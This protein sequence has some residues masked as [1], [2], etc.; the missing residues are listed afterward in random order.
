MKLAVSMALAALALTGCATDDASTNA[1]DTMPVEVA[2]PPGAGGLFMDA[3]GALM[4]GGNIDFNISGAQPGEMVHVLLGTSYSEGASCPPPLNG[5][6]LDITLTSPPKILFSIPADANGDVSIS[7]G[8]PGIP[9]GTYGYLQAAT[10]G[11]TAATSNVVLKF[12][13]LDAG[14][15]TY[16]QQ[17]GFAG[18]VPGVSLDGFYLEQYVTDN[19]TFAPTNPGFIPS[20]GGDICAYAGDTTGTPSA[21]AAPCVGCSF[22]FDVTTTNWE[23]I[24]TSGDCLTL[25]GADVTTFGDFDTTWGHSPNYYIPGF[26]YD[27]VFMTYYTPAGAAGYWT[28]VTNGVGWDAATG[29]FVWGID[30]AGEPAL[31]IPY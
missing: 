8:I 26:G 3:F 5:L 18:V 22:A 2:A 6:C 1:V 23:D 24:S 16:L 10:T 21:A 12:E 19:P 28:W 27:E 30:W 20:N 25:L 31:E 14:G 7:S 15:S 11:A 4:S 9:D 29:E 13:L 17:F